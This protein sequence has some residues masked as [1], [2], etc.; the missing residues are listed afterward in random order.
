MTH[1]PQD[2]II[3]TLRARTADGEMHRWSKANGFSVSFVYRVLNRT[4]SPS[5]RMCEALGYRRAVQT[6]YAKA[7]S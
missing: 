1:A 6:V 7:E 5:E 2:E 3:E 4:A